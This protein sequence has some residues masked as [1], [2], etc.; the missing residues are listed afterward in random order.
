MCC[1]D[2]RRTLRMKSAGSPPVRPLTARPVAAQAVVPPQPTPGPVS[3]RYVRRVPLCMK[4]EAT[5]HTYEFSSVRA[6][7]QVDS[8]DLAGLLR[9]GYFSVT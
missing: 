3:I 1:G 2:K 8:R 4:G 7:Q 9:S 6:R 5:G